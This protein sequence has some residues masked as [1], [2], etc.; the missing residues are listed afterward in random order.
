MKALRKFNQPGAEWKKI[1]MEEAIR[2]ID[3]YY[4]AGAA[5]PML[6]QGETVWTPWAQF[7][8]KGARD[9]G[10]LDGT[11][12]EDIGSAL[13][14]CNC[15]FHPNV[16]TTIRS[17]EGRGK[18]ENAL[19]EIMK[20]EKVGVISAMNILEAH[21]R[22]GRKLPPAFW[23]SRIAVLEKMTIKMRKKRDSLTKGSPKFKKF[24]RKVWKLINGVFPPDVDG[25]KAIEKHMEEHYPEQYRA[26]KKGK[27]IKDR[28]LDFDELT[29]YSTWLHIFPER[30]LGQQEFDTSRGFPIREVGPEEE[31]NLRLSQ[32]S[33]PQ[34]TPKKK[35]PV[36]NLPK[37]LSGITP[38]EEGLL[39]GPM[40]RESKKRP[41]EYHAGMLKKYVNLDG[42]TK[43]RRQVGNLLDEFQKAITSGKVDK[44][45]PHG[46]DFMY[47]QKKL[48]ALFNDMKKGEKR[49]LKVAYRVRKDY[50]DV[51][52]WEGQEPGV[53]LLEQFLDLIGKPDSGRAIHTLCWIIRRSLSRKRIVA[54][55]TD[56]ARKALNILIRA[57][58]NA[59]K[60]LKVQKRTVEEVRRVLGMDQGSVEGQPGATLEGVPAEA[61][62]IRSDQIPDNTHLQYDFGPWRGI[63]RSPLPG[64]WAM[65]FGRDKLGKSTLVNQFAKYLA[66]KGHKVLWIEFEEDV[67]GVFNARLEKLRAK[68]PNLSVTQAIPKDMTPYEFVVVNSVS[69]KNLSPEYLTDL[70]NRYK[71][72]GVN[73]ILIYKAKKDGDYLGRSGH[74]H[75]PDIKVEIKKKGL[76]L[77]SGRYGVG[78]GE[79]P[80]TKEAW[81]QFVA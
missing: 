3:N 48:L 58:A 43:S 22:D 39:G 59:V 54:P 9:Q 16:H 70:K 30:I 50:G 7:K 14:S 44:K 21:L 8:L 75:L 67:Y 49:D 37:P 32:V 81:E 6:R 66:H 63:F 27:P 64:F 68:H 35:G 60:K 1:P 10:T 15:S 78:E 4:K 12:S 80:Y 42:K 77:S 18:A 55:F 53:V 5:E 61:E 26:W 45:H 57:G 11:G 62:I 31:A 28:P 38:D 52:A 19:R 13:S 79:I 34:S 36:P 47:A 65:V 40:K 29:R 33:D 24:E 71:G 72:T 41:Y 74:G 25:Q 23:R 73:F 56:P 51:I 76:A 2:D 20:R 46:R 69:E 17:K